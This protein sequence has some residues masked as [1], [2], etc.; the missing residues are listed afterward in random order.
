MRYKLLQLN[1]IS[2]ISLII[3]NFLAVQIPFYGKTPGDVS[4]LYP[5]L[6]T[7][8]NFAFKIW[9]L[10]YLLL[11]VFVFSDIKI[12][13]EKSKKQPEEVT[14]TGYLFLISC[15][16]NFLWL[17]A[18]QSMHIFWSFA[19]IFALWIILIVIYYRL[20]QIDNAR[21]TNKLPISLYLAWVCVATLANMNV[22]LI[23]IDFSF[24]N[25]TE[26]VWTATLIGIGIGGT[27]L[28]LFLSKDILFA[29][30]LIW[31]YYGMYHKNIV[32]YPDGNEVSF[33]SVAAMVII[34]ISILITSGIKWRHRA[35]KQIDE[36]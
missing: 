33:M 10:V 11:A 19:I 17:I 30:V 31:A 13:V 24:F 8:S 4:D 18:W 32:L 35:H 36:G 27:L 6:L 20:H 14:T 23:D 9:I 21:Y 29:I 5:N 15:I 3:V 16:L 22:L 26:E 2:Y 34:F 12:L 25:L 28:V 1:I 7:P